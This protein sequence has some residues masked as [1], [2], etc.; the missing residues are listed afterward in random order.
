[1]HASHGHAGSGDRTPSELH[2]LTGFLSAPL[3]PRECSKK[4]AIPNGVNLRCLSWNLDQGWIACGG[5]NGL[6]KVG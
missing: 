5:E 2:A 4:I 6:L 3:P 1:M